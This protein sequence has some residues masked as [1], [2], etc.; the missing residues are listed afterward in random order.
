MII[1]NR[2]FRIISFINYQIT[3]DCYD[4]LGMEFGGK[5]LE[6]LSQTLFDTFDNDGK[7]IRQPIPADL[8]KKVWTTNDGK[9]QYCGSEYELH[10]DHIKPVA[11][12]DENI[13][14]NLQ[15]L[16]ST[17]NKQKGRSY[18]VMDHLFS[19]FNDETR[20]LFSGTKWYNSHTPVIENLVTESRPCDAY[21]FKKLYT[22]GMYE[23]SSPWVCLEST[24]E[25]KPYDGS[26]MTP[27]FY[28]VKT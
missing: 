18:C 15:L 24:D 7:C 11:E 13:E 3:R 14:K 27:G 2:N 4:K 5:T 22:S 12:G 25:V 19:E 6:N 8:K 28:I 10:I 17:C 21:D 20:E 16:C 1:K 26:D 23:N 9:C